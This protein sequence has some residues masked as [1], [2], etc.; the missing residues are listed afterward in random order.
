[1][2]WAAWESQC[3]WSIGKTPAPREGEMA[4]NMQSGGFVNQIGIGPG[5]P[6]KQLFFIMRRELVL[7][8][9]RTSVRPVAVG[10]SGRKAVQI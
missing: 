10:L 6:F 4:G 8:D 7:R 9:D 3:G 5:L 1:M 2:V